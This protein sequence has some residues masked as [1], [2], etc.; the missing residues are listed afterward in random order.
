MQSTQVNVLGVG[1]SCV[2]RVSSDWNCPLGQ[3]NHFNCH[4][5]V[6]R[7]GVE[8]VLVEPLTPH[9]VARAIS[10]ELVRPLALCQAVF[11]LDPLQVPSSLPPRDGD[12]N[13]R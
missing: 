12:T 4:V 9:N 8:D 3:V 7:D 13:G 11:K 5:Q 10:D 1:M 6:I 2:R